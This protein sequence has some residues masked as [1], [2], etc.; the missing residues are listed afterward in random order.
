MGESLSA[1]L[2]SDTEKVCLIEREGGIVSRFLSKKICLTV[3]E[4]LVGETFCAVF[5][6]CSGSENC[7]G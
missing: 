2:I 4:T 1:S 6:N 3:P 5:Q 7:Y